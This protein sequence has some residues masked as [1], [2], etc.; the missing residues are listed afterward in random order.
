MILILAEV[1]T[2]TTILDFLGNPNIALLIGV[3][4]SVLLPGRYFDFSDVRAWIEKAVKRSGVVLLDMCG[5]GALGAT[6]VMT[7]AG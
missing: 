4:L 7:G 2:S 5:G 6:L 1:F 3:A